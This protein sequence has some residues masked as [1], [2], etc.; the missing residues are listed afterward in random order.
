MYE[1]MQKK[2]IT[3]A[4]FLTPVKRYNT[5]HYSEGGILR[6]ILDLNQT[7]L[8]AANNTCSEYVRGVGKSR[9]PISYTKP[10]L[11]WEEDF[12]VISQG[13]ASLNV[14]VLK[15]ATEITCHK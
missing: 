15:D 1:F 11:N 12:E 9:I 7:S 6:K 13:R 10:M 3:H 8:L 4:N 2:N 5:T 14:L